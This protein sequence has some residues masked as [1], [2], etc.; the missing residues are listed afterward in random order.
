MDRYLKLLHP[1]RILTT[2]LKHDRPA[3]IS[4]KKYLLLSNISHLLVIFVLLTSKD[5]ILNAISIL[6]IISDLYWHNKPES[7]KIKLLSFIHSFLMLLIFFYVFIKIVIGYNKSTNLKIF[8]P[9]IVYC[10][11]EHFKG[12]TSEI[13][14]GLN[15]KQT[16]SIIM[17]YEPLI[18]TIAWLGIAFLNINYPEFNKRII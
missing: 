10:L 1:K 12:Y 17:K 18:H 4:N 14:N 5:N 13:H 6:Y 9:F 2:L 11:I 16:Y 3:Y 7:N 15:H 8:V